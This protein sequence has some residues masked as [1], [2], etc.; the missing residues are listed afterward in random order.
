MNQCFASFGI[1]RTEPPFAKRL[2]ICSRQVRRRPDAGE[3]AQRYTNANGRFASMVTTPE[4]R[5]AARR[6]NHDGR[7]LPHLARDRSSQSPRGGQGDPVGHGFDFFGRVAAGIDAPSAM[8][9]RIRRQQTQVGIEQAAE[10]VPTSC[11]SEDDLDLG[12][13]NIDIEIRTRWDASPFSPTPLPAHPARTRPERAGHA[14]APACSQT[15]LSHLLT[16]LVGFFGASRT[17][18]PLPPMTGG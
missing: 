14:T 7:R 5:P 12:L 13:G 10:G 4:T 17:A 1:L 6:V 3:P 9:G 15:K 16:T 18:R 8:D 2:Q 11:G